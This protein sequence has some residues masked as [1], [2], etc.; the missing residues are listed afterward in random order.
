VADVVDVPELRERT[1]VFVDRAHAGRVLGRLLEGRLDASA[2]IVAIPAGG[3]P[4]A[5]ELAGRLGLP[6]EVAVVSK[7]TLPWNTESGYGAVAFDGTLR[8]N[9]ELV[10]Y[11]GLGAAEVERGIAATRAKVRRRM[12]RLTQRGLREV[13]EVA[14]R[15]AVV[16]DDGL[17]SG[18]T[19]RVAV[20]A[21][22]RAGAA[23]VVVAVPTAPTDRARSFASEVDAL[24]CANLRTTTGF[25]V[26]DAYQNWSDLDEQQALELI[27]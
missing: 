19:L 25:A 2:K 27:A 6:I 23:A 11:I 14:G 8:L 13:P 22:R 18:F 5:R 4:V 26:A 3:V 9:D 10:R 15:T 20:E 21:L 17:A 12:D 1:R 16:V 7:I 24:Y